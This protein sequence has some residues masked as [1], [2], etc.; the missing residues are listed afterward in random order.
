MATV[1]VCD[2]TRWK[3]NIRDKFQ[4]HMVPFQLISIFRVR[5]VKILS[6][7]VNI[8]A[9]PERTFSVCRLQSLQCGPFRAFASVKIQLQ[10]RL[11][12]NDNHTEQRTAVEQV[13]GMTVMGALLQPV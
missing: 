9:F 8:K 10:Q 4:I 12:I 5:G 7:K 6:I 11:S 2:I 13:Q 1:Y 3:F